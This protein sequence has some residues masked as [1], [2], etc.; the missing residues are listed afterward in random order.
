MVLAILTQS[1]HLLVEPRRRRA[2]FLLHAVATLQLKESVRIV[3]SPV[4]RLR[5]PLAR[6]ITA[7][8][9]SSLDKLIA[10][11]MHLAD[12]ST[13]WLLHKGRDVS[14]EVEQ[15]EAFWDASFE[16]LPSI[17]DP[18]SAIVRITNFAGRRSR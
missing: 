15:A 13:V 5:E 18:Q 1:D 10:M 4:E 8:A 9:V 6:T 17:T 16:M 11:T 2:D 3:Q 12:R 7:R 14:A